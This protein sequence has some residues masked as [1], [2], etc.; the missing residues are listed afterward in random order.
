MDRITE[1][2]TEERYQLFITGR[3]FLVR[4]DTLTNQI[5]IMPHVQ[6]ELLNDIKEQAEEN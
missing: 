3:P 5:E 2:E 6:D 4:L 1:L